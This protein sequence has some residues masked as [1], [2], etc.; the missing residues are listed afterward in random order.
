VVEGRNYKPVIEVDHCQSCQVCL[1][2]CPAEIIPEYQQETATL[3]GLI[4][5]RPIPS[6][7]QPGRHSQPACQQACPIRQDTRGYAALISR[8]KFKEA[9][10]LIREV[11]PLP[12]VCGFICHHPC[13]EACF[14]EGVDQ[15]LPLRLLKRFVAEWGY[16]QG[17]PK[18]HL[19]K[20]KGEKVMV[21]GSGPAGLAAAHDLRLLGYQVTVYEALP[22][23]GGMLA[24][25]IP[26]FRLPRKILRKEIEEIQSLGIEMKTQTIFPLNAIQD[27]IKK[28]G[29]QA[30]F[31]AIGAHK[32]QPLLILGEKLPGVFPGVELL[33]KIN[34]GKKVAIGKRVIVLGGGNVAVD[35][36]RSVL[37]LG[38]EEVTLIYRRS[39]KEMPAIPEEIDAAKREGIN[40]HF[41]AAPVAI[42][43]PKGNGLILNCLKVRLGTPDQDGRKIPIPMVGSEFSVSADFIVSAVGQRVDSRKVTDLRVNSDGTFWADP[44]TGQTSLKGVFAG[45]DGVSGPGWAIEAIAAGKRGAESIH[46]FLS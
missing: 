31:L 35:V 30:A 34:L 36:A 17:S 28:L 12:A 19:P 41:L 24:V 43:K 42:K 18:P 26:A 29:F 23:L 22:V 15:P 4:Y 1:R 14:R 46:R 5:P 33:R 38:T 7:P 9:L 25:G 11:N 6:E 44:E 2:S 20:M 45:G 37:R 27:T 21:V 10:S 13:E 39:R 32:S 3:R 8:G 16:Q 40:F